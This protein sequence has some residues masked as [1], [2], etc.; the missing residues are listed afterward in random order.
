MAN[1]QARK[2]KQLSLPLAKA[3]SPPVI[4]TQHP[5]VVVLLAQLLL[6]AVPPNS[7]A[8][9]AEEADHDPC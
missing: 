6:S 7:R 3:S 4:E 1:H 9:S 2:P 8:D 5:Q